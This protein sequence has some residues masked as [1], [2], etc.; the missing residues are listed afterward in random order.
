[1]I[2][3]TLQRKKGDYVYSPFI[4]D[5]AVGTAL[6]TLVTTSLGC[7]A[8]IDDVTQTKLVTS[9]RDCGCDDTMTFEG[10]AEE[11]RPLL[12]ATHF[13]LVAFDR[14]KVFEAAM[15]ELDATL[16][17][18]LSRA[19]WVLQMVSGYAQGEI[20]LK[21]AFFLGMEL[22]KDDI[23]TALTL[24]FSEL[25]AI[26]CLMFE[27]GMCFKNVLEATTNQSCD[28]APDVCA[29]LDRPRI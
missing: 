10:S 25:E 22:S 28:L 8:R 23:N 7:H 6:A 18:G 20:R 24:P 11:M 14:E 9:Y 1:M 27:E 17:D 29:M 15:Q 4:R 5:V 16:P 2:K 13:Y 21:M 26:A 3:I 19:P 12:R